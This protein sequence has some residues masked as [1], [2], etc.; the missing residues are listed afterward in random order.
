M[1]TVQFNL[2]LTF[3]FSIFLFVLASPHPLAPHA[4][5]FVV[6]GHPAAAA[7]VRESKEASGVVDPRS[8]DS[9]IAESQSELG[10]LLNHLKSVNQRRRRRPYPHGLVVSGDA[11]P[12]TR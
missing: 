3:I 9:G 12:C 2:F 8:F 10:S 5:K 6:V 4:S 1:R 7:P 11:A